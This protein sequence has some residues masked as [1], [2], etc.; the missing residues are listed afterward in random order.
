MRHGLIYGAFLSEDGVS[1]NPQRVRGRA[2]SL[3]SQVIR[4]K[5]RSPGRRMKAVRKNQEGT[6]GGRRGEREGEMRQGVEA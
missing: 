6:N 5:I 3:S 2:G 4:F 1:L